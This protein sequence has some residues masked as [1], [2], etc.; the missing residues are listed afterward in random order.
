MTT[1]RGF[2]LAAAGVCANKKEVE[3]SNDTASVLETLSNIGAPKCGTGISRRLLLP[4][5]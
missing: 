1:T 4:A 5:T 3:M 2:G